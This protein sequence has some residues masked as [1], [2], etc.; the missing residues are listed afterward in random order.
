MPPIFYAIWGGAY[1]SPYGGSF[2]YFF[3][4]YGGPFCYFLPLWGTFF[5]MWDFF[6][7]PTPP[8]PHLQKLLRAPMILCAFS[9]H[10]IDLFNNNILALIHINLCEINCYYA[11]PTPPHPP[12]HTISI[13]ISKC[14]NLCYLVHV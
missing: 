13:I 14:N 11:Y 6:G 5:S 9:R 4:P 7:L 2:S 8:P 3:S 10:N 1:F 12:N